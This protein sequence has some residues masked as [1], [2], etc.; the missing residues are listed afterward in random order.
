MPLGLGVIVGVSLGGMVPPGI[1]VGVGVAV[2][3]TG[4]TV[5]VPVGVGVALDVAV[6][7]AVIVAGTVGVGVALS[8][9]VTTVPAGRAALKGEALVVPSTAIAVMLVAFQ[10]VALVKVNWPSPPAVVCPT[11]NCPWAPLSAK[12]STVTLALACPVILLP[13][14]VCKTGAVSSCVPF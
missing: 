10:P 11:K 4:I 14:T 1:S 3:V 2:P 9:G 7:V 13:V 8:V 5:W 12:I 6:A